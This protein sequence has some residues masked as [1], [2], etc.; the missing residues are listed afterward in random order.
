[1]NET[2]GCDESIYA[3]ENGKVVRKVVTRL[4]GVVGQRASRVELDR[5]GRGDRGSNLGRVN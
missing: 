4:G 1:M 5:R 2:K 3:V